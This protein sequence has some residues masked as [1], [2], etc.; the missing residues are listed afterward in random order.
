MS[1]KSIFLFPK[2][3]YLKIS[4][5][6]YSFILFLFFAKQCWWKSN[7]LQAISRMFM[8]MKIQIDCENKKRQI[9]V[10]SSEGHT[11]TNI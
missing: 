4:K 5:I 8:N 3:Y 9:N 10:T 1:G 2:E 7:Q 6:K 11:F